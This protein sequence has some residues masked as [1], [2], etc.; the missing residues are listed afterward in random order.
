MSATQVQ[1]RRGTNSAIQAT[2]PALAE[3]AYDTTNKRLNLGDGITSGGTAT[4][5]Y[6]DVRNDSF[7]V[8]SVA[9]TGNAILLS[10]NP[11]PAAYQVNMRIK[12]I[13][14]QANTGA[15]TVNVNGIGLRDIRKIGSTGIVALASG[16]IVVGGVYDLHYTGT[17]F[18]LGG[19]GRAGVSSI[20]QGNLVTG[21]SGYSTSTA[22][23]V[24]LA[25]GEYG[26]WPTSG[27][28]T[29]STSGEITVHDGLV[30]WSG[31]VARAFLR[32]TTGGGTIN[33]QQRYIASSPPF[34]LGDGEVAGFF[35]AEVN[36]AGE[37]LNTYIADVP[38]WAYNGPTN[39]RAD[40]QCPVTGKKYRT[41]RKRM[42]VQE[43]MDGVPSKQELEEITDSI[44]N[45]DMSIIPHPFL[46]PASDST[47]VLIDPMDDKVARLLEHIDIGGMGDFTS[48][49]ETGKLLIDNNCIN[50]CAP[51]GVSVHKLK[52]K[53]SKKF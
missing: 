40:H 10:M 47:I 21:L 15:T 6:L 43:I 7:N 17:Y 37:I 18:Q 13:A 53:F 33:M 20:R 39:I 23:S 30:N 1:I 41:V 36:P 51:S 22:A 25:G 49:V 19:S 31:Y 24:V 32:K 35:F 8:A 11:A 3:L 38:P 26:F 34:N 5:N 45:A 42:S 16:D 9:G 46:N 44:K 4:P 52:Y 48:C 29:T 12:F 50:R 28:T 14:T 2:V 27:A